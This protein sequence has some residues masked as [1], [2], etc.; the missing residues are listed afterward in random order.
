MRTAPRGLGGDEGGEEEGGAVG[1]AFLGKTHSMRPLWKMTVLHPLGHGSTWYL[2]EGEGE[3]SAT[4]C[5][6]LTTSKGVTAKAVTMDPTEPER[7][8][9]RSDEVDELEDDS[10][11]ELLPS[12]ESEEESL[13]MTEICIVVRGKNGMNFVMSERTF[14]KEND[15]VRRNEVFLSKYILRYLSVVFVV[16]RVRARRRRTPYRRSPNQISEAC[17]E[18]I[19]KFLDDNDDGRRRL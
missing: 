12:S 15:A 14:R 9:G 16:S 19:A 17:R 4:C 5:R 18:T 6:I 10:R 8:L 7:I 11:S 13:L 2:W 1:T 3:A